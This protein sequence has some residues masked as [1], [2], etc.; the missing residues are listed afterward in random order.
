MAT[1]DVVKQFMGYVE[2]QWI[3]SEFFQPRRW[4]IFKEDVRT[5]NDVEGWHRRL[6]YNAKRGKLQFYLLKEL[7]HKEGSYVT[8][9]TKLLSDGKLKRN[10]SKK[11]R[12]IQKAVKKMWK[13]YTRNRLSLNNL[14][15]IV[16]NAE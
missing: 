2:R 16:K 6:N 1:D 14:L 5:N 8:V 12:K 4:C 13:R 15:S 3:V 11:N 7:L 10:Q 9:Q